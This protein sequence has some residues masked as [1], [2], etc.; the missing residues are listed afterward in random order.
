MAPRHS[1]RPRPTLT[2]LTRLASGPL[3]GSVTCGGGAAVFLIAQM[4]LLAQIVTDLAF[5]HQ[6]ITA[7]LPYIGVLMACVVLRALFQGAA[8]TLGDY[9]GQKVTASLRMELLT[10][11]FRVGPV[12]LVGH[13]SGHIATALSEG[14]EA[15]HPFIARYTPRAA[16]MVVTPLLILAVV[17][18]LDGWSCLILAV[19][20]PLIP[21]FMALVGYSAQSIMDRKWTEL[22]LL[23][24]S[25]LDMLQGL[26]TLRLF[27]RTRDGLT[28]VAHMARSH[29]RSTM[30]VMRVA[31][32]TS[33]VLE[34]FASLAIALVAVVFG[35]RLLN[36]T[37][38]FQEA[39]FVLL[40]AP[41]FFM[42]LRAFSASYHA[43]QNAVSAFGP[44][45]ELLALP[46]LRQERTTPATPPSSPLEA[47]VLDHIRAGYGEDA[48][49]LHDLSASLRRDQITLL[50]GASGSGKTTIMRL[51][52]S[53][54]PPRAGRCFATRTDGRTQPLTDLRI[55]WVPQHPF[56]LA[57]SIADNLRLAH[58]DASE[59]EL[60]A[61]LA[62]TALS[63]VVARLPQGIHS[64]LGERGA[65]LSTG[66][67]RRLALA[68]ALLG[69]PELLL[70]DEPTADL[71]PD[72][73]TCVAD[74]IARAKTGRVC[75][76][77][78]HRPELAR[79]ADHH[80]TLAHGQWTHQEGDAA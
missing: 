26:T 59:A 21:V 30:A 67:I 70:F 3:A 33:A 35:A 61:A 50:T 28:L 27:G 56:L 71:D 66:Q 63:D 10:H 18:K 48:D 43:R 7:E 29:R 75:L 47:I 57:G 15:L 25:F 34:F 32:L 46:T 23:G 2:G 62:D 42:P 72:N 79:H 60:N 4:G 65:P 76:V 44:I 8:D 36:V 74:T 64:P 12:G 51:L 73:A 45:G 20:G 68:R 19:T 37:V 16:A 24:A 52:L 22:L 14:I 31:F 69:N 1:A 77:I 13:E 55:G 49:I 78:A 6:T 17:F 53:L 41:E 11:L 58:P 5:R 39:F 38:A 9:A 80:L 54:M 40:L